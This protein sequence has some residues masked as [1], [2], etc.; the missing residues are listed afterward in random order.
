MDEPEQ[1]AHRFNDAI[2]RRDLDALA[3]LM[4]EDHRFVDT[5][6]SVVDGKPACV[7]A[8][9]GFFASFPDYR[10]E[11]A[12]VTTTDDR[13][14]IEGRSACSVPELAGPARWH[15]LVRDGQVVE[16]RVEDPGGQL[17]V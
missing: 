8:W 4:T 14:V 10:N 5:A 9:R 3:D 17:P 16:W 11:F 2:N 13:V 6:G 12:T 15:A 7:D 1:T